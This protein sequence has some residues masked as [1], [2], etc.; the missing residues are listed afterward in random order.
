MALSGDAGGVPRVR[1]HMFM[2]TDAIAHAVIALQRTKS[3]GHPRHRQG[4]GRRTDM[5]RPANAA[6]PLPHPREVGRRRPGSR[7]TA[8]SMPK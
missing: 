5:D 8:R 1:L 3:V 2:G 7:A 6:G 4:D